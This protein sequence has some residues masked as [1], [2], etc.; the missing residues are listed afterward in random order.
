VVPGAPAAAHRCRSEPKSAPRGGCGGGLGP[1]LGLWLCYRATGSQPVGTDASVVS[2]RCWPCP[3]TRAQWQLARCWRWPGLWRGAHAAL[4][5]A[6]QRLRRAWIT[7]PRRRPR[8]RPACAGVAGGGRRRE[9]EQAGAACAAD[10]QRGVGAGPLV[11]PPPVPA[12]L[13]GGESRRLASGAG[14][15][16]GDHGG[17]GG[18]NG[19]Q[20]TGRRAHQPCDL[21]SRL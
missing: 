20:Y 9:A 21:R 12:V 16:G 7:G 14:R 10:A 5:S 15:R 19:Q 8:P 18:G 2:E 13:R 4:A 3:F 17:R 11:P 6:A 1:G